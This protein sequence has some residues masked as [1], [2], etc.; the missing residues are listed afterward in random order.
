MNKFNKELDDFYKKNIHE[1]QINNE[2]NNFIKNIKRT[3]Y[4]KC[5]DRFMLKIS[6]AE[7][8]DTSQTTHRRFYSTDFVLK[9]DNLR[10]EWI[11]CT[12]E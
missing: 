7:V 5:N 2:I 11:K 4:K 10:K 12:K 8:E 1:Q 3:P 6:K 9:V